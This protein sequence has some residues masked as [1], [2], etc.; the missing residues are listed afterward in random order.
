MHS[1]YSFAFNDP[2]RFDDPT[3]LA[4]EKE[5]GAKGDVFLDDCG[6]CF[7]VQMAYYNY[8]NYVTQLQ[9]SAGFS[10]VGEDVDLI[11]WLWE[12]SDFEA[13][14]QLRYLASKV[15]IFKLKACRLGPYSSHYK[16][17]SDP[18]FGDD[19][20]ANREEGT[21][22][23]EGQG[24]DGE[25]SNKKTLEKVAFALNVTG[26]LAGIGEYSNVSN[27]MWLGANG[28][29]YSTSW[30]GNQWTGARSNVMKTAGQFKLLG[31]GSF[32]FTTGISAYEGGI[33]I[34]EGDYDS[35]AKSGLDITMAGIATFGGTPGLII[36]G[37]YFVLDALGAFDESYV[38]RINIP[39]NFPGD[40]TN[41]EFKMLDMP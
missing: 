1:P 37:G 32:I 40:N 35:A 30:G 24:E 4:P 18:I 28:K 8:L 27:G 20:E 2:L 21:S 41:V 38:P 7:S 15:D 19:T 16:K 29:W 26:T 12:G 14:K 25:E 10:D 13:L 34:S 11:G 33:A 17:G 39:A 3:G 31:R 5:K 9:N 36:G 22:S 23:S 6:D